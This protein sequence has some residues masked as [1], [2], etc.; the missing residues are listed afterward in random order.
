MVHS[1]SIVMESSE[2]ELSELA[3]LEPIKADGTGTAQVL[4]VMAIVPEREPEPEE[5]EEELELPPPPPPPPPEPEP[6]YDWGL[7][8]EPEQA[9]HPR[10][11]L[12]SVAGVY[13][14]DSRV[15]Y[16]SALDSGG[17]CRCRLAHRQTFSPRGWDRHRSSTLAA[18]LARLGGKSC[19][20]A[21]LL[22]SEGNWPGWTAGLDR[23]QASG[24]RPFVIVSWAVCAA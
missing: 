12:Y 23:C 24:P 16:C 5:E 8:P 4:R 9:P 13:P 21:A 18:A 2:E 7:E 3:V 22:P 6:E 17:T 1:V 19:V 10:S 15:L 20:S 11:V 14:Y